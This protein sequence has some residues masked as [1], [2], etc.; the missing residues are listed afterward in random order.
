MTAKLAVFLL[1]LFFPDAAFPQDSLHRKNCNLL[2]VQT[3]Y[4][5]HFVQDD[6]IS[7]LLYS[8]SQ[9][10]VYLTYQSL[11]KTRVHT[12]VAYFD[13][14]KLSSAIS[15]QNPE[16]AFYAKNYNAFVQ[17]AYNRSVYNNGRLNV[18]LY[19][20]GQIKGQLNLRDHYYNS[21]VHYNTGEFL[22]NLSLSLL[23][24]KKF[25]I[26]K[27][28]YISLHYTLSA[29][30]YDMLNYLYNANVAK[31]LNADASQNSTGD[32][33]RKNS[34]LA[35]VNNYFEFQ[36]ELS[37]VKFIS[38]RVGCSVRTYLQYYNEQKVE[39]IFAAKYVN[40]QC[41]VGVAVKL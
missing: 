15:I 34:R 1:I 26:R 30:A 8:G 4:S 36:T 33:I 41:T 18:R 3:G 19:A 25:A 5:K 14:L 12:V 17:Y 11:G 2:T 9:V 23:L 37:Y 29:L 16:P 38:K 24:I 27:N 21:F 10:P 35:S 32:L 28:D 20:G 7:P 39:D 13:Y 6:I 31:E 22:T 40:V